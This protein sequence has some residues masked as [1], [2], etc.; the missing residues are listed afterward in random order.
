MDSTITS[1]AWRGRL[2]LSLA[3]RELEC[4]LG[5]AQGMTAKEIARE[6][7]ISP[8]TVAKRLANAMF[9]LQVNRQAS[10]V[11]EAMRR[12]IITPL[13][14]VLSMLIAA[15]ST[16]DDMR[17]ERKSTERRVAVFET[18]LARKAAHKARPCI[19]IA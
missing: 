2:G 19:S 3:P 11:A 6:L 14:M 16:S 7:G 4:T 12:Q 18:K 9:K 13:C 17:R 15:H 8:G 5:L 1:G 10:L